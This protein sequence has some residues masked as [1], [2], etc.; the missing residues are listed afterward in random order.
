MMCQPPADYRTK[1]YSL[2]YA[3]GYVLLLAL[4]LLDNKATAADR[5][6]PPVK[7][8]A[9]RREPVAAIFWNDDLA[10]I[11]CAKSGSLI[12][13]DIARGEIAQEFQVGKQLRGVARWKGDELLVIDDKTHEL[14]RLRHADGKLTELDR[15]SVPAYPVSLVAWESQSG[16]RAAVASLWSRQVT[17]WEDRGQLSQRGSALELPI[18]PR[19]LVPPPN[20]GPEILLAVPAFGGRL[21]EVRED[22]P[23]HPFTPER[24][25]FAATL[26]GLKFYGTGQSLSQSLPLTYKNVSSGK[27]IENELVSQSAPVPLT[28][29]DTQGVTLNDQN[30]DPAGLAFFQEGTLVCLAGVDQIWYRRSRDDQQPL[31]IP[32]G[33]R[34]RTIIANDKIALV[35][36]ELDDSVSRIE[37]ANPDRPT[38]TTTLLDPALADRELSPAERG[39]RLFFSGKMSA[40]GM[41]SCHSCHTDGHT[42]GLLADTLGDNTH[43]TPKRVL[44]LRGTRLT[45]LWSWNGEMKTLQD[46]VFKSLKDTMHAPEIKPAD[47]D[48]IVSFLHTLPPVPPL[49]PVPQGEED[50]AQVARGEKIFQREYCGS[51]HVPPL[52]FTSHAVYD[53]GLADEKGLRK[54]N[55]PSL[56]G[57]GRLK[58][59]FHDNRA[60]SLRDVFETHGHQL[61]EPLPTKELEDLVRYLESL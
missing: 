46:N 48:D 43:G 52:T 35:L 39:E 57:V 61:V 47:V 1:N 41:M 22:W 12:F 9:V 44:T 17:L 51:C 13:W 16:K 37:F 25:N 36:G 42:N 49:K 14:I 40:G 28:R 11:A 38:V 2:V 29:Q 53:V 32:V 19:Q 4:F 50:R 34:P 8:G 56:R 18:E 26:Q 45:D 30:A 24:Q 7:L 15:R 5:T 31:R 10:L 21:L 23:P 55:P 33:K 20:R 58:K 60:S 59:L 6:L 54:F 3:A 27:I